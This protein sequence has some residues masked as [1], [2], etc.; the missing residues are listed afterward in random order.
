MGSLWGASAYCALNC[1]WRLSERPDERTP[2]PLATSETVLPGN[3]LSGEATSLHHQPCRFHAQPF[4]KVTRNIQRLPY[5]EAL[6]IPVKLIWGDTDLNLNKGVA[7]D[8]QSHLKHAS[9]LALSAG[10]WPQIDRPEQVAKE[11]L[12]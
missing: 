11:M 4:E 9:L 6:D 3:F 1:L 5:L 12:A 8:L 2:H 10:H 7:E